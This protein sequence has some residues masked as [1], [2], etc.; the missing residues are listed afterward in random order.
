[1]TDR[2]TKVVLTF[3]AILLFL[4]LVHQ[5]F[6]EASAENGIKKGIDQVSQRRVDPIPVV[7]CYR[8]GGKPVE[9]SCGERLR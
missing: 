7:H 3:I 4:N 5:K 2:Y 8:V 9:W 1:M 6:P